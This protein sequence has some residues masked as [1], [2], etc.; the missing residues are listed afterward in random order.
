MIKRFLILSILFVTGMQ[1]SEVYNRWDIETQIR[2]DISEGKVVSARSGL[3]S[4][5][6][7]SYLRS[8]FVNKLLFEDAMLVGADNK[9]LAV[10][11]AKLALEFGANPGVKEGGGLGV[12]S[13]AIYHNNP[14]LVNLILGHKYKDYLGREKL[15]S[16]DGISSVY[17]NQPS[18]LPLFLIADQEKI[19]PEHVEIA[20][21]LIN[22]GA[23]LTVK[24]EIGRTPEEKF[25]W[26]YENKKK[27]SPDDKEQIERLQDIIRPLVWKRLDRDVPAVN[28]FR[29]R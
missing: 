25:M 6:D 14:K 3:Q 8:E 21:A 22:A 29:N 4:L 19:T 2:N 17:S 18:E 15:A 1:A 16:P 20:K 27:R 10:D 11:A 5:K 24:D 12:L 26:V 28:Y 9:E 7:S 23:N 13:T